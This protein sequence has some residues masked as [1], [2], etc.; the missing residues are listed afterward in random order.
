MW[1]RLEG[2]A[3]NCW[4]TRG[5]WPRDFVI[6]PQILGAPVPL[7]SLWK[8]ISRLR[9]GATNL[10]GRGT[11]AKKLRKAGKIY[12]LKFIDSMSVVVGESS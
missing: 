5:S 12:M 8:V 3:G 1:G 11:S 4:D 10:R 2:G 7:L 9:P 6:R